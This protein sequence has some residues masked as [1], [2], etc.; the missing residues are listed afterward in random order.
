MT[1]FAQYSATA[2]PRYP[3]DEVTFISAAVYQPGAI[4]QLADGRAAVFTG[5]EANAIGDPVTFKAAGV[6]EVVSASATTFAIGAQVNWDAVGV[7]AVAKG[8]GSFYLGAAV[9]AK[10]AGDVTVL[11]A[12]NLPTLPSS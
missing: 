2:L 10:V 7:A 1:A 5:L 12:L 9:Q 11:V 4:I 6:Y 8:N 3:W